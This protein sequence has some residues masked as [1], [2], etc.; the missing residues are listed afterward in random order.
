MLIFYPEESRLSYTGRIPVFDFFVGVKSLSR[1]PTAVCM[2]LGGSLSIELC[3]L[4]AIVLGESS[5]YSKT[6]L[7]KSLVFAA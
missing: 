1:F 3:L 4:P 5:G 2:C 7:L 6:A